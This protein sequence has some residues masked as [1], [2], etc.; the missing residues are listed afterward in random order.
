MDAALNGAI[1]NTALGHSA[2]SALTTGDSNVA[3][4]YEAGNDLT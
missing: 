1:Y 4:G 3:I 2:L